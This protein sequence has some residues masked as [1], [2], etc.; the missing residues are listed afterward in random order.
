MSLGFREIISPSYSRGSSDKFRFNS[1]Q[2]TPKAQLRLPKG[3]RFVASARKTDKIPLET[4]IQDMELGGEDSPP[5]TIQKE[6]TKFPENNLVIS[7]RA[8]PIALISKTS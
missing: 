2:K 4:I 7:D 8:S 6:M 3:P 1:A 5:K